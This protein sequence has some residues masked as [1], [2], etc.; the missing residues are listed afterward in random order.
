[1]NQVVFSPDG[2][3]LATASW[4]GTVRLWDASTRKELARLKHDGPV[5][6]VEFSP[7]GATLATAS[8]DR[9]ARLWDAST[10]K[11]LARLEHDRLVYQVEFSPDGATLATASDDNT[12][13][14]WHMKS[15]DL[16]CEAVSR[17]TRNLTQEEWNTYLPGEPYR[18]TCDLSDLEQESALEKIRDQIAA[19]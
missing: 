7:I 4:D 17:L 16:I 11:E 10:R 2:A 14:L 8:I 19:F 12:V 1:M 6:Q 18:E 15:E 13:R 9:T 5:D 3:T